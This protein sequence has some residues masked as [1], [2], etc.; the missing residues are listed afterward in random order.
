M[1]KGPNEVNA[2]KKVTSAKLAVTADKAKE[3]KAVRRVEEGSFFVQ[4]EADV[5][6]EAKVA[7][8]VVMFFRESDDINARIHP[9]NV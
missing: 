2:E 7:R 3:P 6:L 5:Q 4:L 8:P 9:S 1:G